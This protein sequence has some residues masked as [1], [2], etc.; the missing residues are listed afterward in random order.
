MADRLIATWRTRIDGWQRQHSV[1]G[2]PLAVQRKYG[3]D[4]GGRHAALMTYYGFLSIFPLLLLLVAAVTRIL[5]GNDELRA[6]FINEIVP[7]QFRDTV[8]SA[9]LALPSGGIPFIVGIAGVIGTSLGIASTAHD[10]LNHVAG[11]PQRLRLTGFKRTMRV[12]LMVFVLLIGL[13]AVASV[14]VALSRL[15]QQSTLDAVVQAIA[16]IAVFFAVMWLG[17]ILLLPSR[18]SFRSVWPVALLAAVV[19][20]AFLGFGALLIPRFIERAGPVYGAFATIVGL[21]AFISLVCQALVYSAE[22][23]AVR[24]FRLWPRS[25]DPDHLTPADHRALSLLAREQERL[26]QQRVVSEFVDSSTPDSNPSP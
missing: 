5:S 10:T 18:P 4:D 19:S 8:N 2:F 22:V 17:T 1:L 15:P 25:L 11:V 24:H 7:E 12:L 23:A 20:A 14:G 26:P 16:T 9:L 3:E 13:A 21:L 6:Q